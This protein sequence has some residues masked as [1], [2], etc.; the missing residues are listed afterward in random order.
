MSLASLVGIVADRR[1]KSLEP[2]SPVLPV[3]LRN[4]QPLAGLGYVNRELGASLRS[5]AALNLGRLTQPPPHNH[6]LATSGDFE[7]AIDTGEIH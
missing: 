7:L 3:A 5:H 1:L 4:L 2:R 6:Q